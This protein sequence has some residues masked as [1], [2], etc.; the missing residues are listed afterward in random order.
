MQRY[1]DDQYPATERGDAATPAQLATRWQGLAELGLTGL[2]VAPE[3]GG[4]GLGPVEAMLVA[5][6]LPAFLAWG[7]Y[8]GELVAPLMLIVGAQVRVA[9]AIVAANMLVAIVLAHMGDVFALTAH[10]GWAIELQVMLL[11]VAVA[12]LFLGG[13]RFGVQK[14]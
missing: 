3:H 8:V 9:A 14:S 10:G 4:S 12:L 5:R 2:L 11:A 1:C 6:D 7:V 13:G